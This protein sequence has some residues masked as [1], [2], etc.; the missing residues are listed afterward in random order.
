MGYL[1]NI[2]QEVIRFTKEEEENGKLPSLDLGLMVNREEKKINFNVHYKKTNTNIT[3]KKQSNHRE[4]IKKGVIKGYADQARRLCDPEYIE[5]EMKNIQEVFQ[6]NGYSKDEINKA[7]AEREKK[8]T[9]EEDKASRGVIVMPNIPGFTPQFNKIAKR[10]QFNVANN[11]ESRVKDLVSTAKTPLGGKNT[12]V[13]YRI[14]CKCALH[15]YTGETDRKWCTREKE[16][17]DKVRLT[18]TDLESERVTKRMNGGDGGLAKHAAS[19]SKG[20]DW[21]KV[22]IIGKESGWTQ[23]K[24]LEGIDTLRQ[25]H[26]G[27]VPLNAYNQMEQWQGLLYTLFDSDKRISDVR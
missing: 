27:K 6:D 9:N 16:H 19:C 25:K 20:I 18:M 8:E 21:E 14:P 1:N 4:S 13:I 24:Y 15:T 2:E 3:L 10:H 17:R 11:T 22:K 26:E 23:R 7:M 5:A 12:N